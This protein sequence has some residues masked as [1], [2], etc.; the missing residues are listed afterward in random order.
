LLSFASARAPNLSP[1]LREFLK[2]TENTTTQK[3]EGA[4]TATTGKQRSKA[5]RLLFGQKAGN[6]C[7]T[8][9]YVKDLARNYAKK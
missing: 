5:Q 1:I 4:I 7:F 3:P 6:D 2:N 9:L 8:D